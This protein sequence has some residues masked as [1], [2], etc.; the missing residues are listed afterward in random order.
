MRARITPSASA[1]GH[2]IAMI[3]MHCTCSTH[4]CQNFSGLVESV[5]IPGSY[6]YHPHPG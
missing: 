3:S 4:A 1:I 5:C 6:H 2:M